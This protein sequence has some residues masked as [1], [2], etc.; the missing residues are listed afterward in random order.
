MHLIT[1]TQIPGRIRRG[2]K[3]QSGRAVSLSEGTLSLSGGALSL[4][5]KTLS[6]SAEASSL[7]AQNKK[8]A[9]G[10]FFVQTVDKTDPKEIFWGRFVILMDISHVL[11]HKTP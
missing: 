9:L 5:V 6:L 7:S 3:I 1:Y 2:R 4:S 10:G 8:A 11:A